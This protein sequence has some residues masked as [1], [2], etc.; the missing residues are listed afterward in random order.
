MIRSFFLLFIIVCTIPTSFAGKKEK[1]KENSNS[2][3]SS[4][5]TKKEVEEQAIFIEGMQAYLLGNSQD[6]VTKFNEVLR[7][8]SRNDAA[9]YL[10]AKIAFEAGNM[11]KTIEFTQNAIKIDPNNEYYYQ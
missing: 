5:I 8:D 10:L 6:A 2:S 4:P 1:N 7:R 11:D 3:A 9:L